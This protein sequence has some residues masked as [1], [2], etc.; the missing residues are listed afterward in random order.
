MSY[1]KVTV[2]LYV[3]ADSPTEADDTAR[4]ELSTRDMVQAVVEK[5]TKK[6]AESF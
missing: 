3:E 5:S 1:Y 4:D 6:E 2:T